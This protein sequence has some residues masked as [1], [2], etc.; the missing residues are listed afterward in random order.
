MFPKNIC[1][2]R[3]MF[4]KPRTGGEP[5]SRNRDKKL[6][7]SNTVYQVETSAAISKEGT[8][9]FFILNPENVMS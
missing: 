7:D 1:R 4:E 9:N 5:L 6:Y 8:K 3:V 2:C